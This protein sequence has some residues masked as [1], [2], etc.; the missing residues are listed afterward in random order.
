MNEQ[1]KKAYDKASI[2]KDINDREQMIR[3]YQISGHLDRNKA[4]EKI[5]ELRLTD[6]DVAKETTARLAVSSTPF[7]QA[8]DQ[9]IAAELQ[10][11]VEILSAKILKNQQ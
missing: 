4:I 9:G 10:M 8:S 11:Q 5:Q 3:N 7:S 1:I 2:L 6:E